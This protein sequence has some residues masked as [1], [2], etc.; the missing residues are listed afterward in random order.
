MKTINEEEYK[1]YKSQGLSEKEIAGKFGFSGPLAFRVYYHK[2]KDNMFWDKCMKAIIAIN[3]TKR[4]LV[5]PGSVS[6]ERELNAISI[7]LKEEGYPAYHKFIKNELDGKTFL[8]RY[9]CPIGTTLKEF[10]ENK[11]PKPVPL[12]NVVKD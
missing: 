7:V 5:L 3:A 12:R 10:K 11:F 1:Q 8:A 4:P 2:R 9:I 6:E